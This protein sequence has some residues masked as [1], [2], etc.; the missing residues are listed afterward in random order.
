MPRF[1]F[2]GPMGRVRGD[3]KAVG[4]AAQTVA[5]GLGPQLEDAMP[6]CNSRDRDDDDARRLLSGMEESLRDRRVACYGG[7]HMCCERLL[8]PLG[9]IGRDNSTSRRHAVRSPRWHLIMLSVLYA[10]RG[11]GPHASLL[12]LVSFLLWRCSIWTRFGHLP[13]LGT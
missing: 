8:L 3:A 4:T 2:S 5:H 13:H 9:G 7:L 12:V 6:R 11:R 1:I 10:Q